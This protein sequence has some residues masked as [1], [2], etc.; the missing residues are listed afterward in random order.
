MRVLG[1]ATLAS[2]A[3]YSGPAF[4]QERMPVSEARKLLLAAIDAPDGRAS[5][6]LVGEAAEAIT[7][8]F[9]GTTGLHVD[10]TTLRRYAQ[11][12]CSRLNMRVRQD[13]VTLPGASAP[14]RQTI[15][16]GIN[17]C[18]DGLPPRSLD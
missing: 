9:R 3:C 12:G 6:V 14:G 8:R 7:Q 16:I 18:R 5:G 15:D 1:L 10:V 4:A 17:Y 11:P 2:V 13:G